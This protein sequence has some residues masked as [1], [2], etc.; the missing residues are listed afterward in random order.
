MRVDVVLQLLRECGGGTLIQITK[1][2]ADGRDV[3]NIPLLGMK[4]GITRALALEAGDDLVRFVLDWDVTKPGR[5]SAIHLMLDDCKLKTWNGAEKCPFRPQFIKLAEERERFVRYIELFEEEQRE[6][7]EDRHR[8]LFEAGADVSKCIYLFARSVNLIRHSLPQMFLVPDGQVYK[9]SEV[10]RTSISKLAAKGAG[11]GARLHVVLIEDKQEWW[12]VITDKHHKVHFSEPLRVHFRLRMLIG[13]MVNAMVETD[14][15]R[16]PTVPET[17]TE[18][19]G[20][21]KESAVV[22]A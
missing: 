10:H 8:A 18:F 21:V 9:L 15:P 4:V 5:P 2:I 1:S 6:P 14:W 3:Y 12:L 19:R 11:K 16:S 13:R 7:I 22:E 17:G 20:G